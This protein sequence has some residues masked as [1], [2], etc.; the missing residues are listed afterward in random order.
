MIEA[1]L[2]VLEAAYLDYH[3]EV[4]LEDI[5]RRRNNV[6]INRVHGIISDHFLQ[7]GGLE[8]QGSDDGIEEENEIDDSDTVEDMVLDDVMEENMM[9]NDVAEENVM[10]NNVETSQIILRNEDYNLRQLK[11]ILISQ[12]ST[13]SWSG[14][15]VPGPGDG[16]IEMRNILALMRA[17]QFLVANTEISCRWGPSDAS[18]IMKAGVD[19]YRANLNDERNGDEALDFHLRYFK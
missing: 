1:V 2:E 4:Q 14:T 10:L 8:N 5:H 6:L 11:G 13:E 12:M 15:C 19:L 7:I 9:L 18:I 16:E 17:G 3:S